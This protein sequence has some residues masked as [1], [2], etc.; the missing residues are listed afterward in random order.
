MYGEDGM[1]IS[2]SQFFAGKHLDFLSENVKVLKQ[3]E[4]L[5]NFKADDNYS[6]IKSHIEKVS[7]FQKVFIKNLK[8]SKLKHQNKMFNA[9]K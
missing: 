7:L 9:D 1:D 2:K 6:L 4:Q 8:Y 3:A 5:D